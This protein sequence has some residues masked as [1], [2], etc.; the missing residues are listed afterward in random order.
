MQ[1]W[2]GYGLTGSVRDEKL[3]FWIGA[4]GN[5]KT[6]IAEAISWCMGDYAKPTMMETLLASNH[7]RHP[8]EIADLQ[9][10]RLVTAVESNVG[11]RWDEGKIKLLTGSDKLKA[12]FMKQDFFEF[13]PTFKLLVYSHHMPRIRMADEA[14]RR[15][16]DLVQFDVVNLR[17]NATSCCQRNCGRKAQGFW[18]GRF[19]AALSG[20]A[21][22][23]SRRSACAMR[24]TLICG[25]KTC[26]TLGWRKTARPAPTGERTGPACFRSFAFYCKEQGGDPGAANDFYSVM[27]QRGHPTV[28][29]KGVRLLDR[30]KLR[31]RD[32]DDRGLP[33]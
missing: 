28:T 12:R 30:I 17:R 20:S 11:R 23:S 18:V 6:K 13:D 10:A 3:A 32:Y 8:T 9:G 15:R 4:G 19:V 2:F 31:S 33:F 7:E 24:L 25:A 22:D 27:E 16:L 29:V 14:M 1:R 21:W 5:G 26:S